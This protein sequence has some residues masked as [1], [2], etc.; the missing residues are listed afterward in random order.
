MEHKEKITALHSGDKSKMGILHSRKNGERG[1]GG[2][3]NIRHSLAPQG[4]SL[5][6]STAAFYNLLESTMF[7]IYIYGSGYILPHAVVQG[8]KLEVHEFWEVGDGVLPGEHLPRLLRGPEHFRGKHILP[9]I[10]QRP[11]G[12]CLQGRREA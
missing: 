3:K 4:N 6:S 8:I 9:A 5:Y 2:L 1:G 11:A 7:Y 12:D 10:R